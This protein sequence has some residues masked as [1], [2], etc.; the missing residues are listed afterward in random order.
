VTDESWTELEARI[1]QSSEYKAL[2]RRH[3]RAER[4]TGWLRHV[5]VIAP[6][7][8]VFW[9]SLVSEGVRATLAPRWGALAFSFLNDGYKP[10]WYHAWH[11]ATH[12]DPYDGKFDPDNPNDNY[13]DLCMQYPSGSP[14]RP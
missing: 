9:R 12:D 10:T 14:K 2:V 13:C 5:P 6:L 8:H 7:V 3:E 11:N 1:T 4:L